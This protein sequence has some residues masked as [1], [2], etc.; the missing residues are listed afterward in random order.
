MST[1]RDIVEGF[2]QV[3][4]DLLIPEF[5]ALQAEVRLLGERLDRLEKVL[6]ERFAQ[7]EQRFGQM[8]QRFGQLD[9]RFVQIEQRFAQVDQRFAQVDARFEA[10]TREMNERFA[11]V[12]ARFDA[13]HKEILDLAKA[14]SAIDGKM[15][16]LMRQMATLTDVARLTVR[17]ENLEKQVSTLAE[18]VRQLTASRS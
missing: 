13:M 14:V 10:L 11:R 1:A 18:T 5:K 8:E 6:E 4:R 9:Q 3:V 12:D 15:D 16:I 17:V 7:V 2:R